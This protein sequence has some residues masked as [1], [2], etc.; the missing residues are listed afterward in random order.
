MTYRKN[1]IYAAKLSKIILFILLFTNYAYSKNISL[2]VNS[3]NY[4]TKIKDPD[5]T[6]TNEY[7][8]LQVRNWL[9][10]VNLGLSL[11][12]LDHSPL[13]L[14][15]MTNRFSHNPI[16]RTV[17]DRNNTLF[18]NILDTRSDTAILSYQ[19]NRFVNG[20]FLSNV[21]VGKKL[22]YKNQTVGSETENAILYGLN[23]NYFLTRNLAG[24][25]IL[26]APNKDLT[27]KYGVGLGINYN[28]NL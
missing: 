20:V 25:L 14:T 18:Q 6:Y 13:I 19:S 10:S 11:R 28:F 4:F 1:M 23:F 17:R 15:V 7:D 9:K 21:R 12:P 24:S 26:I 2:V 8:T 16:S 3:N 27:M 5:Y 22:V